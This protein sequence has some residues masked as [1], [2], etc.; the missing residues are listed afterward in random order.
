MIN[1]APIRATVLALA[2]LPGAAFA[3]S[4]PVSG[5]WTY[6]N[7]SGEGRA[8]ECGARHMTFQSPQ[9]FDTGSG[10]PNYRNVS[11]EDLGGDAYRIVDAFTTGQI[12]AR[13]TY[14]LRKVD[15]DHITL[16]MPGASI[17]LRRCG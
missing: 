2:M 14:V 6:E 11:V 10:V 13:S 3:Q 7:P 12:D 1:A 8:K 16:E 9:R 15:A 17:P 5:K 4:Y